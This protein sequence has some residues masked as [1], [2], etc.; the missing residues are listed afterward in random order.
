MA[1]K[2]KPAVTSPEFTTISI[3]GHL[4]SSS[5][6]S[7]KLSG[8]KNYLSWSAAIKTFLTS[9]EKLRYIEEDKPETESSTWAK[10]DA[11]VRSWLWNS[12]EPHVSCD[13]IPLLTAYA[14]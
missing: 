14:V 1:A 2:D 10:E 5:I 4:N 8:T 11:Q 7:S 6:T 3:A 13:V 9:K 12:M